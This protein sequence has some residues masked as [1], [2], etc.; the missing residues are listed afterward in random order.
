MKEKLRNIGKNRWELPRGSRTKEPQMRVP[1][2]LIGTDKIIEWAED[3]AIEQLTN[4]TTLPGIVKYSVGMPDIHW[5]YGLPMGAVGAFD[6][7][8]GIIS[9]GMTGFDINCGIRLIKTNL[10]YD[11]VKPKLKELINALFRNVP[12]GVGSKSKLRLSEGELEDVMVNGAG[13]AVEKGFGE[14]EDLEHL[15]ERGM[16]E[17]A[18]TG[19]VS[20]EAKRRGRPQAGTLGAGNHFLEIQRIQQVYDSEIAQTY[21]L[22]K[23]KVAVMLHCGSRGFGHQIA[24]DYLRILDKAVK[25][26]NIILPDRQLVC[27]PATSREG[28]AYFAAMKAG[29]NYAFANR[30]VMTHSIRKTFEDIFNKDSESLG[31]DILYDVCHNICKYEEHEINGEN[32]N[33]YVHRKG[34]TRAFPPGH[35]DVPKIYRDVGQPVLIAG[36]MGT[37]SYVL[38]GTEQA[39]SETFGSTCH[40][41]GRAMSRKKAIRTYRGDDIKRDLK[42]EGRFVVA[43]HPKVIAEE[44]PG[45]YKDVDEVIESVHGAGISTKVARMVPLAVAKG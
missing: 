38:T 39:M 13:W 45:A 2:R 6:E 26:Y 31:M 23:D 4:V 29:V 30:Q 5:G 44:A 11:E 16:M 15:E 32:R 28:Q 19:K 25:K 33:L 17:G 18:D 10:T 14:K 22:E 37:A 35:S 27:A 24:T 40:G 3:T 36:S 9:A 12:S 43:T 20:I 8:E 42:K 1:G 41:A 34:A 21:A 7:D